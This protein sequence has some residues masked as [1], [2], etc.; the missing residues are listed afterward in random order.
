M[1]L[2]VVEISLNVGAPAFLA[3]IDACDTAGDAAVYNSS[4][5]SMNANSSNHTMGT[6]SPRNM[7]SMNR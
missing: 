7:F 1:L 5:Y 2:G 4:T 3:L 6:V